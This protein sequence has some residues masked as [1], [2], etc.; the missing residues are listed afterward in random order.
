MEKETYK[1][2]KLILERFDPES[3][4]KVR[5][6]ILVL[7][8]YK[9]YHGTE[10]SNVIFNW[11]EAE[12]PTAGTSATPRPGQGNNPVEWLLFIIDSHLS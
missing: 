8:W 12:L 1:T 6:L 11:Q 9:R 2:A 5:I 3:N 10:L 4:A 7:I